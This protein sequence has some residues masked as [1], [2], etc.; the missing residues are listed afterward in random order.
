MFGSLLRIINIAFYLMKI[1]LRGHHH[2]R[3]PAAELLMIPL[4]DTLIA[5]LGFVGHIFPHMEI[6]NAGNDSYHRQHHHHN[7]ECKL[8]CQRVHHE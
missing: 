1:V 4:Q 2:I 5:L 6:D 8:L 7:A 3:Q